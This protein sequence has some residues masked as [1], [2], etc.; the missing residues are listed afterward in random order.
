MSKTRP[1]SGGSKY[2]ISLW[3][4][5][6]TFKIDFTYVEMLIT[7]KE[8]LQ[9]GRKIT[10]IH[11]GVEKHGWFIKKKG[12]FY[13]MKGNP[14][15]SVNY[16]E[17]DIYCDNPEYLTEDEIIK[18]FI[19]E[20]IKECIKRE[21]EFIKQREKEFIKQR[22]R[23]EQ[24]CKKIIYKTIKTIFEEK[25]KILY[26]LLDGY[27]KNE[28]KSI[29]I[30]YCRYREFTNL[31][32]IYEINWDFL[33]KVEEIK[34]KLKYIPQKSGIYVLHCGKYRYIG[35]SMNLLR[36]IIQHYVGM[37]SIC[38]RNNRITKIERIFLWNTE[39]EEYLKRIENGYIN[40]Y[41]RFYPKEL[42]NT[43]KFS[44]L[45]P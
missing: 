35:Q 10:Y 42:V 15:Y 12:N 41:R 24:M 3:I 43:I 23:M 33:Q 16:K 21:K 20:I 27:L 14:F 40:L 5:K 30:V 11:N 25:E 9:G 36:R 38:T 39:D 37:G 4:A 29:D 22:K 7:N 18:N 19:T 26:Y 13:L 32:E 17:C 6:A 45:T 8:I 1:A 44:K 34:Q 2:N 28:I 31:I